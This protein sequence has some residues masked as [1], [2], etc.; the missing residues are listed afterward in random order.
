[1]VVLRFP[2]SVNSCSPRVRDRPLLHADCSI[3]SDGYSEQLG[4]VC[5]KCP[6]NDAGGIS[7]VAV[8]AVGA[9][10]AAAAVISYVTLG[11]DGMGAG[12]GCIERVT[13]YIPLQSV[14]I[15]IAAWQ[16]LTQV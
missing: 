15:V 6:E 7:I 10:I 5:S 4:F 8:L 1:M 12:R 9:L 11:E 3:C 14:K 13:R 2:R 16:I